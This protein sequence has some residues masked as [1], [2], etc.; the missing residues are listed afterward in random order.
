MHNTLQGDLAT[1][2]GKNS[3]STGPPAKLNSA[4]VASHFSRRRPPT[5]RSA[6]KRFRR[7]RQVGSSSASARPHQAGLSH[8]RNDV[9]IRRNGKI[10]G[11][12]NDNARSPAKPTASNAQ[13]NQQRQKRNR[14]TPFT[15]FMTWSS[16]IILRAGTDD[17]FSFEPRPSGSVMVHPLLTGAAR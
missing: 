9:A 16:L 5:A 15:I 7:R 17:S 6:V 8:L 11:F 10:P 14:A 3:S 13:Q 12:R 2:L 1:E 4:R